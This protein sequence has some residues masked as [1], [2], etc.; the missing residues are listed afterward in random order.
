MATPAAAQRSGHATVTGEVRSVQ[1]RTEWI[2][3][4]GSRSIWTF[5]LDATDAAGQSLGLVEVEM[6]GFSFEGSLS[7]GDSVRVG[8][9]WRSGTLRAEELQNLTTGAVVRAKTYKGLRLAAFALFLVF[10]AGIAFFTIVAS[11][12]S[13]E[14]RGEFE[15]RRQEQQQELQGELPEGYCE[16]AEAAGFDRPECQD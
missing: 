15:R 6:R 7:E 12:E 14:R 13:D 4:S 2:G 11:R 1:R 9:R 16:A 10:A 5:R 8:G 3:E